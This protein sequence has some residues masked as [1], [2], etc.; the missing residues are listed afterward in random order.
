MNN[1]AVYI[2]LIVYYAKFRVCE[3]G[4]SEQYHFDL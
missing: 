1:G 2:R 4:P 3:G